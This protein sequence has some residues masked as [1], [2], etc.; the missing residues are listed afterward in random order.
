LVV[1]ERTR[2]RAL[3]QLQLERDRAHAASGM[4][5]EEPIR[6]GAVRTTSDKTAF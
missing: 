4:H 5:A 1:E 6:P 3:W 2:A